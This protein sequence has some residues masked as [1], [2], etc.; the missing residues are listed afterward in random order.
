M[1]M[2]AL[3]SYCQSVI[4]Q[5]VS[6]RLVSSSGV[7]ILSNVVS[8]SVPFLLLP[9]MTR[10]LSPEDVGKVA[11]FTV[12]VNLTVPLVGFRADGAI[13]RQYYER[14]TIDFSN[15][16]ANCLY[17][18]A[19]SATVIALLALF[20]LERIASVLDL[21]S[22]W[23]WTIVFVA[24]ARFFTNTV[25]VLFQVQDKPR[26]YAAYFLPQTVITFGL[27]VYLIVA[28]GYG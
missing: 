9:V 17:I 7:Y 12:A 4:S 1:R 16:I 11:M 23:I 8:L 24:I 22:A 3:W 27:S 28:L 20:F 14:E 15:Y 10:Y 19:M 26:S 2:P 6:S 21:P 13:G 5:L 25:L 18:L